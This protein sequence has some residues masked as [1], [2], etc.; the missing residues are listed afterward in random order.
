MNVTIRRHLLIVVLLLSGNFLFAQEGYLAIRSGYS[1]TQLNGDGISDISLKNRDT[2]H[3]ALVFSHI[4]E[5]KR[6]GYS[7]EPGYTIKGTETN[8]DTISYKFH[9]LSTPLL[10][11]IYPIKNLRIGIGPEPSFLLDAK[12]RVNDTL[13]VDITNTYENVFELSGTVSLSYSI[14]FFADVGVRYN[15]SFTKIANSDAILNRRNL[16]NEYVQVFLLLKIAN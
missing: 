13:K 8:R 7:I 9:Y 4:F 6:F 16:Y 12:N 15:R 14:S 10:L 1:R 3:T 11:D 5:S 2:W